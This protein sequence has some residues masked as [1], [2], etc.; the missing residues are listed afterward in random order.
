MFINLFLAYAK[1]LMNFYQFEIEI[2]CL[3]A[4]A[5]GYCDE[6]TQLRPT[7]NPVSCSAFHPVVSGYLV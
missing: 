7:H 4:R 1:V 5:H 6:G 2:V 3:E